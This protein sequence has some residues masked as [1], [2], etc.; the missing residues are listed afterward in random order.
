MDKKWLCVAQLYTNCEPWE[1][2]IGTLI[3]EPLVMESKNYQCK[4]Y[5]IDS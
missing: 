2:L 4:I 3:P 1:Q 5:V